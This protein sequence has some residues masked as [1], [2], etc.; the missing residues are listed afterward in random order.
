MST[1][2]FLNGYIECAAWCGL[3]EEDDPNNAPFSPACLEQFAKDCAAFESQNAALLEEWPEGDARAGHDFWL[4][5]N[6]HG[7]GF[8]DRG[9][10]KLGELLTDAAHAFGECDLYVGDDGE[11]HATGEAADL[12]GAN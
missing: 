5:R 10:G 8:W 12:K 6:G 11:I 2:D 3:N 7:A 9:H 4:T 1:N